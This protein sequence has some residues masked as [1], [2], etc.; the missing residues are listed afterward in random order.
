MNSTE[1]LP[2]DHYLFSMPKWMVPYCVYTCAKMSVNRA[3]TILGPVSQVIKTQ[4]G[5][6]YT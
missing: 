6:E 5:S 2:E 4:F 3:S 1:Q